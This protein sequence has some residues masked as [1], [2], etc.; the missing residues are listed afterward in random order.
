MW[1]LEIPGGRIEWDGS[2]VALSFIVAFVVCCVGCVAMEHM[3]VHFLRQVVFSTLV[4]VG[5]GSMHYIG[6][7]RILF[8]VLSHLH[9][10][11]RY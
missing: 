6:V 9:S 4:A 11:M 10:H 2:I 1:A 5:S 3:E 8:Y 7:Y